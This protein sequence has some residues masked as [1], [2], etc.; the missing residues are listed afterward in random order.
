MKPTYTYDHVQEAA[1]SKWIAPWASR[2][3]TTGQVSNLRYQEAKHGHA[4]SVQ[5]SKPYEVFVHNGDLK[6]ST[7]TCPMGQEGDT[8]KHVLAVALRALYGPPPKKNEN[9]KKSLFFVTELVYGKIDEMWYLDRKYRR[10]EDEM[11]ALHNLCREIDNALSG[12]PK[13]R[14]N[15]EY[16]RTVISDLE[17]INA[18]DGLG[19]RGDLHSALEEE[20]EEYDKEVAHL[21]EKACLRE[22]EIAVDENATPNLASVIFLDIFF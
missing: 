17:G 7:C 5:G 2:L 15:M 11:D 10:W 13:T 9:E 14:D 20:L 6:R 12:L 22:K 3:Y 19:W 4:A 16:K 8:C 21:K 1:K 18:Q